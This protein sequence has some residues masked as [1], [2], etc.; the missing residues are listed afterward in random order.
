[1][2]VY[3]LTEIHEAYGIRDFNI[4]SV[5]TDKEKALAEMR[6]YIEEDPHEDF[7][8]NGIEYESETYCES[9]YDDNDCCFTAYEIIEKEMDE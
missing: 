3:I 5:R 6:R 2:K 7:K 9:N 4:I 8:N 1:M